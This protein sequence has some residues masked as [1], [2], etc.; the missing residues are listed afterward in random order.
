M[1]KIFTLFAAAL[2]TLT[3]FAAANDGKITFIDL[4]KKQ[5]FIE[6]DGRRYENRNQ[7]IVINNLRPGQHLVQVYTLDQRGGI[8]NRNVRKQIMYNANVNVKSRQ[9]ILISINRNGR[10]EIDERKRQRGRDR[11]DNWGKGRDNDWSTND[12]DYNNNDYSYDYNKSAMDNKSFE[13]LK[14]ALNRENF[15]NSRLQMAKQTIDRNNFNSMQVREM[16]L[17]F[18]FEANKLELAKYAYQ[19]TTD[20]KNYFKVYDVFSFSSSKEQLAD[21]IRRY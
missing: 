7:E 19:H 16:A 14:G 1:K 8:F 15:E 10:V 4:S 20:K 11:D 9:H 6:V 12:R 13:M 3:S 2:V 17:L 5:V 18:A 21:Y